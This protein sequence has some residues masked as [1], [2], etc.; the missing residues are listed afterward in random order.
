MTTIRLL[1]EDLRLRIVSPISKV[2]S[3]NQNSV[4]LKVDFTSHW[5][6]VNHRTAV[7]FAEEDPTVYEVFLTDGKCTVPWEVLENTGDMMIGV[8]G[9]NA[10]D[11]K[12]KPT[13]LVKY[14]RSMGNRVGG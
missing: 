10:E 11:Q 7:F 14:R 9:V 6:N 4:E 2:A 8:R 12:I 5:A 3:G 1:A 13:T